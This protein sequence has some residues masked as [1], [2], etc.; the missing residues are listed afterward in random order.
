[1]DGQEAF[2]RFT[3]QLRRTSGAGGGGAPKGFI[4]GGGL[5]VSLVAGGFLLN[6]SLFN[7]AHTLSFFE[8]MFNCCSAV[9]GGHRAIKY[10]R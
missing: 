10:T 3:N 1:M 2:R 4:A 5:L 7:G 9:D 6:A 8:A